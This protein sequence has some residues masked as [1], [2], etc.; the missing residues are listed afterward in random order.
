[1][2]T[3]GIILATFGS[4]YEEAVEKSVGLMEARICRAYPEAAVKRVFLSDALVDKWNATY[5][6]PV[7]RLDEAMQSL[8]AS[9]VSEIYIQPFIFVADQSY[10]QLRKQVNMYIHSSA[11]DHVCIQLGRPLLSSLGVKNYRDDYADTIGAIRNYLG[12]A[13]KGKTLLLMANGK[14]Q[15]EF[16]TLQLKC[17][18]GEEMNIAVF[19]ANGFPN[20]KQSLQLLE[21]FKQTDIILL[22]PLALI[23]SEHLMDFL[24]GERSDSIASLLNESGY[25]VDL[26]RQGLG[27]NRYIQDIFLKHLA[28]TIRMVERRRQLAPK[29]NYGAQV[30]AY[31]G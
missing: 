10:Q 20:F 15:L 16:S 22:V 6:R 1:M 19:T 3:R 17:L 24:G 18:Y 11:Y 4:I 12:E 26:W 23:G 13:G 9:G 31:V 27:E 7:M 8:L 28:Q 5:G 21:Q 30:L 2:K 14:N 29:K 25:S